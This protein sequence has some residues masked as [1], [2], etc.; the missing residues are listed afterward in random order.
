MYTN[1]IWK[2]CN[3]VCYFLSYTTSVPWPFF[4]IVVGFCSCYLFFSMYLLI[5]PQSPWQMSYSALDIHIY[6]VLCQFSLSEEI[7][8]GILWHTPPNKIDYPLSSMHISYPGSHPLVGRLSA[9]HSFLCIAYSFILGS[10]SFS[11]KKSIHEKECMGS[12]FLELAFL[13]TSL[14]YLTHDWKRSMLWFL[15][16][17]DVDAR[18][19]NDILFPQSFY[20]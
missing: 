13:K 18:K 1:I 20:M 16:A 15:L 8:W 14:L 11:R 3:K 4:V 9:L 19:F 6:Q 12:K 17:S 2:Q 5:P 7:T 10:T